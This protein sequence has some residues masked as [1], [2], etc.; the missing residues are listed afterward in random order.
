MFEYMYGVVRRARKG[1]SVCVRTRE[2]TCN[3]Q[4]SWATRKYVAIQGDSPEQA[5]LLPPSVRDELGSDPRDLCSCAAAIQ[6]LAKRSRL[7][8][9]LQMGTLLL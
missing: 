9:Q 2:G 3:P 8:D 1:F 5:Y 6:T 4:Q 7:F